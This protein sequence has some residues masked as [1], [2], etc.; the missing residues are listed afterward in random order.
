M[1][2]SGIQRGFDFSKPES[3]D[4][5]VLSEELNTNY[6]SY[7]YLVTAFLPYLQ[8]QSRETSLIFTTSGLALV[9]SVFIMVRS[10]ADM[11]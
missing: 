6:L 1:L 4:L 7:M 9:N 5:N 8:K 11:T 10:L 3:I 2:N